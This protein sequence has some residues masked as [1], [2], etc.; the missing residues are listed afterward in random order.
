MYPTAKEMNE[1]TVKNINSI[2]NIFDAIE[3]ASNNW[4]FSCMICDDCLTEPVKDLLTKL[5]YRLSE[6]QTG[7]NISWE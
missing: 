6:Y 3:H 7:Y 1:R 5:G 4:N 2:K